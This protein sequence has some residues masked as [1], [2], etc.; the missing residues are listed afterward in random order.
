M[1]TGA[2]RTLCSRDLAQ[3]LFDHWNPD[4]HQ[5]YRIFNGQQIQ[6]EAMKEQLKLE[7]RDGTTTRVHGVHFVDQVLSFLN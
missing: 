2:T 6:R 4:G 3:K 5:Q 1:D 7:N